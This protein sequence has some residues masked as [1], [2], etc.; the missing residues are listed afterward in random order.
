MGHAKLTAIRVKSLNARQRE[1][2]NFAKISRLT[3]E[4]Q[5][6]DFIASHISGSQF[7]K[8]LK[9]R[10]SVDT[11]YKGKDVWICLPYDGRWYL[12]PHGE[13]WSGVFLI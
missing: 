11:K 2:Y 9:S 3:D 10:L 8:Q 7:L 4:W 5:G 1:N 6:A 12:F 13:F